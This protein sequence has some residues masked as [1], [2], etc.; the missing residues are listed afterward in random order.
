LFTGGGKFSFDQYVGRHK[1]V[2]NELLFLEEPVAETKKVTDFLAGT[3]DPK[4]E[5]EIQSCM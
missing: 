4:M 2:Y 3:S 1:Q 5:T